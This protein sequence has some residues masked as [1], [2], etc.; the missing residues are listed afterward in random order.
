MAKCPETPLYIIEIHF[1][2]PF[3]SSIGPPFEPAEHGKPVWSNH[4]H[5]GNISFK[6]TYLNFNFSKPGTPEGQTR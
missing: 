3:I 6:E 5:K 1:V 2:P 4:C